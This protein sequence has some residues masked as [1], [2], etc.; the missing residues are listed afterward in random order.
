MET[1]LFRR[2]IRHR[3]AIIA[4]AAAMM[5]PVA[6]CGSHVS[7]QAIA[8][9]AHGAATTDAETTPQPSVSP[10]SMGTA[11]DLTPPGPSVPAL[12]VPK[13]PAPAAGGAAHTGT[14][15]SHARTGAV[16]ASS[17]TGGGTRSTG[18]GATTG[19]SGGKASGAA[20]AP[21]TANLSLVKIG[22]LGVFSGVLGA[23]TEDGPKTLAAWVAYTNASGGLNGHPLKMTVGDDQGDPATALTLARR[24]VESDKIIAMVG[25]VNV[26][27]FAQIDKYLTDKKIPMVGGDGVDPGWYTST[28]TF[29]VSAPAA[30]AIVKGLKTFVNQGARKIAMLYCLE[31][32]SLCTYLNDQAKKSP[33]V[34]QYIVESY[35]VSLVA[36]SYTSQCLRMKQDGIEVVYMLMDTAGAARVVQNCATQG[37]TPKVMLLGLDA[38]KDMPGIASLSTATVP[39]AT[40]PPATPG[41][42]S[43]VKYAKVMAT[44]GP[45]VG[46]SGIGMMAWASAELLGLVGKDL[47]AEPTPDSLYAALYRVSNETLGGLITSVS[48]FK[49]KPAVVKP[50]MFLWATKAG[51]WSA[52]NGA[53]PTC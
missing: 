8:E 37:F 12:S 46:Q 45:N 1:T 41:V 6:G 10:Q 24:M 43:L 18:A 11:R 7:D 35:Q 9:A 21:R 25:D 23:I 49:G 20:E 44:Y 14:A 17:A 5:A 15:T 47:P 3:L 36:P 26:F 39:G 16:T 40:V 2:P 52:P 50:C 19:T 48:Y 51:R 29:P 30:T 28:N 53:A 27:G 13:P 42:A 22:T 31:V 38:T 4:L 34:G 33:E 32:S